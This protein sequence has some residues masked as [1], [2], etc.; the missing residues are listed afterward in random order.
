MAGRRPP[1]GTAT[2][3]R[4]GEEAAKNGRKGGRESGRVRREKRTVRKILE[5]YLET[6]ARNTP[7]FEVLADKIGLEKNG[8]IKELFVMSCILRSVEEGELSDLERL[9]KMLGEQAEANTSEEKLDGL[10]K[11]FRNAVKSETT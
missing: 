10:L 1:D 8:S 9:M 2:Q 11:E 4:S 6:D 5:D 7:M 3:F